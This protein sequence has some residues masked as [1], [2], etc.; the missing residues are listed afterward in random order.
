MKCPRCGRDTLRVKVNLFLDIP[1]AL[2]HNLSKGDLRAKSVR[3][4]GADWPKSVTY[5]EG[6]GCFYQAR[7]G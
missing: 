2:A 5:C 3:V 1:Q 7:I 4:E 6:L